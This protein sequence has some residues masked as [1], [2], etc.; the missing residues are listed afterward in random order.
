MELIERRHPRLGTLA[1][2]HR[3]LVQ[4]DRAPHRAGGIGRRRASDDRT[5]PYGGRRGL[6]GRRSLGRGGASPRRP[7]RPWSTGSS[8][9]ASTRSER[10]SIRN[11]PEPGSTA[12]AKS[13]TARSSGAGRSVATHRRLGVPRVARRRSRS[14]TVNSRPPPT[15]EPPARRLGAHRAAPVS[16]R[17]RLASPRSSRRKPNAA[18][19]V[20][21]SPQETASTHNARNLRRLPSRRRSVHTS[22][23]L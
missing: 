13:S 16:G 2:R 20:T 22:S 7:P 12:R 5:C 19:S 15:R 21:S 10:Q 4:L 9:R 18:C 23:G 3:A 6:G 17:H 8:G 11:M 14:R 1:R